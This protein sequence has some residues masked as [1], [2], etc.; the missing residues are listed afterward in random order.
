MNEKATVAFGSFHFQV[1]EHAP[2][3]FT[4]GDYLGWIETTL[5]EIATVTDISIR[6]RDGYR[7]N[8]FERPEDEDLGVLTELKFNVPPLQ[9]VTITFNIHVPKRFQD[10]FGESALRIDPDLGEDF[11]VVLA[12]GWQTSLVM[13]RPL[14]A[15]DPDPTDAVIVV[16]E[17]IEREF[18]RLG[19]RPVAFHCLGPSP[20]HL[21]VVL[22]PS[23]GVANDEFE[24]VSHR[25]RGY[26]NYEFRCGN[27]FES[28]DDMCL[29]FFGRVRRE[30]D[31]LYR[32]AAAR[33]RQL[34]LWSEAVNDTMSIL[35]A[36]KRPGVR[37][38]LARLWQGRKLRT[39]LISL[40]E[41]ELRQQDDKQEFDRAVSATYDVGP[42][43]LLPE[44]IRDDLDELE[45]RPIAPL[46]SLLQLLDAS[47]HTGR[48]VL[49]ASVAS[50]VGA[51]VAAAATLIAAG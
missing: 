43:G 15:G 35:A 1:T 22:A 11:A 34:D 18:E 39:A 23:E 30:L 9:F 38:W 17:F 28:T 44:V 4:G 40:G 26:D 41:A 5:G 13:V 7:S 16:R 6:A 42:A 29:A 51:A 27:H 48:D 31:I 3:S 37:G 32:M 8:E 2:T 45:P 36:Y 24:R 33:S 50:L 19:S 21:R 25:R 10:E 46:S 14:A 12:D 47:R 20:A 49:L